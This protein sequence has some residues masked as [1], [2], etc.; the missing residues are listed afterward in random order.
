MFKFMV[1]GI[2]YEIVGDDVTEKVE[3]EAINLFNKWGSQ[4]IAVKDS[5]LARY[6]SLTNTFTAHTGGR[7]EYSR[8]LK[9]EISIVERLANQ[10]MRPGKSGGMKTSALQIVKNAFEIIYLKL[11]KNPIEVLIRALENSAP[12]E[13]TTRISYGGIVYHVA[14]DLAPQRRLDLALRFLAEGARK[15]AYSN[16]KTI[17]ESLADEIILA[18]ERDNK[19]YAVSK[20][21]EQE[22]IALSSR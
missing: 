2:H 18:S 14:V 13:D 10:L 5:A 1:E 16:I 4:G 3:A 21:D 19:S 20:R 9:S 6:I 8:F 12:C 15:G 17:D 11:G 7:H 22:R